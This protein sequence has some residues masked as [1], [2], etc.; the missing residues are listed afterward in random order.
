MSIFDTGTLIALTLA[1]VALQL[2][3]DEGSI[4]FGAF[5]TEKVGICI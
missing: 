1:A 4:P 2:I 5:C 3:F